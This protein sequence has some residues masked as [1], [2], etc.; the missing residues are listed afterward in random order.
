[1]TDLGRFL[2]PGQ[3]YYTVESLVFD[4]RGVLFALIPSLEK[5]ETSRTL[6]V[7]TDTKTGEKSVL[8]PLECQGER[9]NGCYRMTL[10][11]DGSLYAGSRMD[12]PVGGTGRKKIGR[13]RAF[14]LLR[15]KPI[16]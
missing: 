8:G 3:D 6:V 4:R 10:G 15:L 1:M 13:E 14:W 5:G 9:I 11:P 12:G 7:T 16:T 2:A